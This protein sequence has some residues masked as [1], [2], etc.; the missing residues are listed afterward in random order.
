MYSFALP[1]QQAGHATEGAPAPLPLT[2]I[3]CHLASDSHGKTKFTKR[4]EH[5]EEMLR[6]LGV[7]CEPRCPASPLWCL[8][9][10][11]C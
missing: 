4:N 10:A 5:A 3:S 1:S 9:V 7:R 2:F 11:L 8:R 6:S